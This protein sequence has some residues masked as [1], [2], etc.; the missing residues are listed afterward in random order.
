LPFTAPPWGLFGGAAKDL[1]EHTLRSA[2]LEDTGFLS[3]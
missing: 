3:L 2:V 1:L